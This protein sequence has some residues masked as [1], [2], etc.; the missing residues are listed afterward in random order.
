MS[1]PGGSG[2]FPRPSGRNRRTGKCRACGAHV[3]LV[4]RDD[5]EWLVA[6]HGTFVL[7]CEGSGS[8]PEPPPP[9]IPPAGV[10]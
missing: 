6:I 9:P 7:R 4:R 1:I 8:I 2:S 3:E 10:F 5:G